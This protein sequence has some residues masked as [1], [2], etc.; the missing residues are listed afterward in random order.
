MGSGVLTLGSL[1]LGVPSEKFLKTFYDFLWART[2]L[3]LLAVLPSPHH[4]YQSPS[5][6]GNRR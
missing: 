5:G 3:Q 2:E 4:F 1:L 6:G